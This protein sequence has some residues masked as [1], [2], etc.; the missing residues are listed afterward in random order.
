METVREFTYV[1]DRVSAGGGCEVA[2]TARTRFVWLSLRNVVT[3]CIIFSVNL[4]LV[5][6]KNIVRSAILY[7]SETL[8]L[9]EIL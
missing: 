5:V 8:F 9:N 7:G 2:M 1:G 3:Y 6:Y 4:E